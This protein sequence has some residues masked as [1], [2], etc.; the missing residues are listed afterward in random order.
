MHILIIAPEP[1][2]A[3]RGT[4]LAVR[5]L[6]TAFLEFGHRV[7]ILTYHLGEEVIAPG[8][9]VYRN[10]CFSGRIKAV[11]PGFSLNKIVLDMAL[12]PRALLLILKNRYDVVHCIEESA[13]FICWFRWLRR[14]LFFFDMDS[15][16]PQQLID[17]GKLKSRWAVMFA[18][19]LE[20]IALAAAD[21]VVTICPLF[22]KRV[23]ALFPD[24]R[25]FQI[26]D[27]SATGECQSVDRPENRT[28]LYTGNFQDYQ[29]VDILIEGF[30][31]IQDRWPD[32]QLLLVGGEVGEIRALRERYPGDRITFA[33]KIPISELPR[34]IA[35]AKILVS[36]RRCGENTPF[37]LYTYLASGKPLLATDVLSH[38]QIVAN[39]KEAILVEPTAEGIAAGLAKLLS[40]E[41]YARRIGTNA[42]KLFEARYSRKGYMEKV[43]R[44]LA[45]M[46]EM[47]LSKRSRQP[48]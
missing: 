41:A 32:M 48:V 18:R 1:F 15:D 36:P 31:K 46:E 42:R 40:D 3:V 30:M 11:R 27:L 17:A 8:L 22:T 4:P 23:T 9:R 47:V 20:R 7:D 39:G 26:E 37:K 16:I 45:Y 12:F 13:Y 19:V 33:G 28:I 2:F 21:G 35:M 10:R 14:F 25:V 29:G 38:S 44:L 24:K 5:E 34:F 43:G 6:A